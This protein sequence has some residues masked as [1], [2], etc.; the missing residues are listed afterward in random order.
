MKKLTVAIC[1][2]NSIVG[3]IEGNFQ[4]IISKYHKFEHSVQICD[5]VIFPEM[6]ICGYDCKDLLLKE[7]FLEEIKENILKI[8]Q[9]T[10]GKNCAILL[11]A[12]TISVNSKNQKKLYN[13]AILIEN[14]EIR[15]IANKKTLPNSEVF[16][17]KR[18]F[19]ESKYLSYPTL[20]GFTLNILVCEDMWNNF[21]ATLASQQ[22]FD[23]SVS[24]NA[25]PFH[26]NKQEE[27]LKTAKNFVK[28][29]NKPLLYCNAI[30]GQDEL[31][32]DGSS[33][34]LNAK[35][36]EI[37]TLK[38]FKEDQ[39]IIEITKKGQKIN[40]T[41]N[42][43]EED[44]LDNDEKTY[45]AC[46]LGLRDYIQKNG[47]KKVILGMS[48]GIDSAIAATIAVDAL[49]PKNVTIYALPTQFNA[50]SSIDDAK[51]CAKNLKLHLEII[52]IEDLFQQMLRTLPAINEIAKQNLQSRIRGNILMSLSNTTGALLLSTGNKSELAV[53]YATIYGDMCGAFNPIKDIYKTEI[54]HLAKWRNNNIPSIALL[55]N[56]NLIPNNIITKEPS[57]E[58]SLNQKDSDSLP[59]YE[60]LDQILKLIIEEQ[61]SI[62]DIIALGFNENEVKKVAKLFYHSEYKRNQAPI[63]P[64]ISKMAF[65]VERRYPIT[66]RHCQ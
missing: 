12:P 17:E 25:S 3:D 38:S 30:G 53:G 55:K 43:K 28:N 52:D 62:N 20:K 45:S 10:V 35:G 14:G 49:S 37:L 15:N 2:I 57:A 18:Y 7:Y 6:A 66:N 1:Q 11:G 48:G 13:S 4:K 33:F 8:C 60:I 16:D 63:G 44:I 56:K 19:S 9:Q 5:L 21:N 58:L 54:F 59:E 22:I 23:F 29:T 41:S 31:V 65:G 61:K 46:I 34:A 27:R 47:F 51:A 36:K 40:I 39:K 26:Q 32:F 64:K 42:E 50:Q 24:I